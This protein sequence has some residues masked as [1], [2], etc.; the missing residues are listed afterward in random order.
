MISGQHHD[1][2]AAFAQHPDC[3]GGRFL[4]RIGNR[5]QPRRPIIQCGEHHGLPF[6]P[7]RCRLFHEIVDLCAIL[8]EEPLAADRDPASIDSGDDAN[9]RDCLE[10]SRLGQRKTTFARPT[11]AASRSRSFSSIPGAATIRIRRGRPSVSVPVLS[12]TSVSMLSRASSASA[13]RIRT[14]A[15]APRP[16]PTMIDIGVAN[17]SAHGQA[18]INTETA[19]SSACGNWGAGPIAYHTANAMT[20]TITTIGT[21]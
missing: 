5:Q 7:H 10:I 3:F 6:R 15:D 8:D 11:L 17:P 2:H 13:F 12:T 1:S 20:A 16:T 19:A 4:N 21:K 18:M 14:P 9:A